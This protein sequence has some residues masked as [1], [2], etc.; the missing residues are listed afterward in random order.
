[1]ALHTPIRSRYLAPRCEC[2]CNDLWFDYLFVKVFSLVSIDYRCE[3]VNG[4]LIT[5]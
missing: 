4:A 3:Q 5:P 2:V 1:V